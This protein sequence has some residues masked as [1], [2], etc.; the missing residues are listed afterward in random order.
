MKYCIKCGAALNDFSNFCVCCGAPQQFGNGFNNT[1]AAAIPYG[2]VPVQTKIVNC[3]PEKLKRL[4]GQL[5]ILIWSLIL[6][7]LLN[8]VGTT[9]AVIA[10][11]FCL[12]ADAMEGESGLKKLD[13]A[14]YMCIIATV[15]DVAVIVFLIIESILY[16]R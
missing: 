11:I 7:P 6:A 14:L 2:A 8:P 13:K 16:H 3:K 1:N 5:P 4:K 10:A 12:Q 15:I 9:L